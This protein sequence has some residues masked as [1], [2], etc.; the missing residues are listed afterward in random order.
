MIGTIGASKKVLTSEKKLHTKIWLKRFNLSVLRWMRSIYG[1]YTKASI[2]RRRPKP[3]STIIWL[4]RWYITH[5]IGSQYSVQRGGGRQL[6]TLMTITSMARTHCLAESMVLPDVEFLYMSPPLIRWGRRGLRQR[7]N[8]FINASARSSRRRR[9][10][11]VRIVRTQ[12]WSK[13]EIWVCHPNKNRSC[14]VQHVHSTALCQ[15]CG[16]VSVYV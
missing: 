7:L 2:G 13:N 9:C 10:M 15:W 1:W 12:M 11:C 14:F 16:S 6:L 4:K 8:T 5:T 3:I